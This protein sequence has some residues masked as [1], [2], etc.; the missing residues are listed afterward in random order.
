MRLTVATGMQR[1]LIL[2]ELEAD[3][4]VCWNAAAASLK[5]RE[6]VNVGIEHGTHRVT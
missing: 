5:T 6:D 2:K 1:T 3:L 4:Q